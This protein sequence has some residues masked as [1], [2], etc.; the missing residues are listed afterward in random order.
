ME[1]LDSRS[2]WT[3]AGR[4]VLGVLAVLGVWA[5]GTT[6]VGGHAHATTTQHVPW[7]LWVAF[8]IFFLGLSAGSFLIATLVYVFDVHRLEPAGPFALL[9][10]LGC[11][12]LGGFLVILDLGHPERIYKVITSWNASS[13]MAWMGIFYSVYAAIVVAA[14]YLALRTRLVERGRRSILARVLAL[15][16]VRLDAAS[17]TRDRRWLRRLG[18]AGIP[19]AIVLPVGVGALFAVAKARPGWFS[20]LLPIL[21]L[22]TALASGAALLAF[23][24][25]AFSRGEPGRRLEA[26]RALVHLALAMVCFDFLLLVSE[27]LVTFYG[28]IPHESVGWRLT[29]FGPFWW[30]FWLVQVGLGLVVPL[31]LALAPPARDR[32]AGLGAAGFFIVTG[33]MGARL[34]L[35]IPPQ[36]QPAFEGLPAAYQHAR[37]AVGYVPSGVEWLVG[38]GTIAIGTWLFLLAR[39]VLPLEDE[40]T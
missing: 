38:L 23:L 10:A 5:I 2:I 4:L 17:R 3:V 18:A 14:L 7:G 22:I 27:I 13:V 24:L 29:L 40:A 35:V 32:L 39:R 6:L 34:N 8:Y 16:S 20:G 11:L 28:N 12:L 26:V 36:I 19:I 1:T 21:F 33:I 37:W 25:A 15:G 31:A 30:V 9:Q